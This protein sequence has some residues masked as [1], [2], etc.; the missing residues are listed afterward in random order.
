MTVPDIKTLIGKSELY[1]WGARTFGIS[2]VNKLRAMGISPKAFVDSAPFNEKVCNLPVL[3]PHEIYN[4]K[5]IYIL[6]ATVAYAKQITNMCI[7][8]GITNFSVWEHL[9][10]ATY[11]IETNNKCNLRCVTCAASGMSN[12]ALH[13][14]P[15]EHFSQVIQKILKEDP[16]T[17]YVQLYGQNE[18]LLSLN[19]PE[20]ISYC[21]HH[22]LSVGF[23]TNLT[24]PY[25]YKALVHAQPDWIRISVS[26]CEGH[27]EKIHR[28]GKFSTVVKNLET[29]CTLRNKIH[30]GLEIELIF[31][32]YKNNQADEPKLRELCKK[33]GIHF[34]AINASVIGLESVINVLEGRPIPKAMLHAL[35]NLIHSVQK[36]AKIAE[37]SKESPCVYENIMLIHSDLSIS[38]CQCWQGSVLPDINFLHTPIQEILPRIRN[39]SLCA[40]CKPRGLHNFYLDVFDESTA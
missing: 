6:I 32:R 13:D 37:I 20:K 15:I 39:S 31:H 26:G 19:L 25:D 29:V 27:Y 40:I 35:P 3:Q 22:G 17:T 2:L 16:F 28:G 30:S 34:H 24:L 11:Y 21:K 8:N 14:M 5:N 38:T 18:P 36:T 7:E 33:L 23:S 12:E 9:V 1:I 10:H 4:K